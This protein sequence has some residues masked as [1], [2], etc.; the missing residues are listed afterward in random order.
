MANLTT[1]L[2][3]LIQ[4][5]QILDFHSVVDAY[6]HV[7]ARHPDNSSLFIMSADRAPAQVSSASDLV[8]YSVEDASALD[9]NAPRGYV[10]RF[11]H[12]EMYK[13]YSNITSV[14]HAHAEDVLPYAITGVPM[15]PVFQMAAFVGQDIP[16]WDIEKEYNATDK[17]D[18]L[19]RNEYLGARLASQFATPDSTSAQQALP[20]RKAILMR[21]HGFTTYGTDI[22]TAVYRAIFMTENAKVQTNSALL[23]NAYGAL[24][25]QG[26]DL[27]QWGDR[28]KDG[29]LRNTFEPLTAQEVVDLEDAIVATIDR[30]WSLWVAEVEADPLYQTDG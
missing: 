29:G 3:L 20:Q 28:G 30:P 18:L 5:N 1:I 17:H 23:S 7:S 21:K 16:V 26:L 8:T 11:I 15:E 9:P 4:A 12:S 2:S 14:I 22:R 25:Q 10:E 19:V 6:G 13:R 24:A 27:H